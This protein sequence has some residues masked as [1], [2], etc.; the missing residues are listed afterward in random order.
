VKNYLSNIQLAHNLQNMK[1]NSC[2]NKVAKLMIK[3][4]ENLSRYN[5]EFSKVRLVMTLPLLKILG[6]EIA[7]C[8]WSL[9]RKRVFWCVCTTAFFG[10][11]RLGELLAPSKN[12]FSPE[13]LTWNKISL[14]TDSA[15]INI[16]FPK[17]NNK[18]GDFV[19]VF[20]FK[21][22]NCCPVA[23]LRNLHAEKLN[24]VD[25]NYPV[26]TLENGSFLTQTDFN[27]TVEILLR[28]YLKKDTS[29]ISGHSFRAAIPAAL[30][31]N[32][33]VSNEFDI[34]LWGRWSS[35]CYKTY[36]RLKHDARR[37]IFSKIELVLNRSAGSTG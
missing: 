30:A 31:N 21:G 34:Q 14:K 3:G 4:A 25:M 23:N 29:K 16:N 22:H 15:L 18:N 27:K 5:S 12:K 1:G 19:D 32:P 10:S 36:T 33:D 17:S 13:T 26:F 11:F 2:N 37:Q 20:S 35:D 24:F 6:H 8:N 7:K 28:P 9:D